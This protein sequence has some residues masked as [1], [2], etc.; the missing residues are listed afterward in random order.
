MKI[1]GSSVVAL[2]ALVLIACG[3]GGTAADAGSGPDASGLDTG[4]TG[5]D[6]GSGDTGAA[7][8]SGSAAGDSGAGTGD[9]S[10]SDA[11]WPG[12]GSAPTAV[13]EAVRQSVASETALAE[14]YCSCPGFVSALADL[15]GAPLDA[16][17]CRRKLVEPAAMWDCL[18]S[19]FSSAPVN[20]VPGLV[21]QLAG[22]LRAQACVSPL[23]CTASNTSA[24]TDCLLAYDTAISDCNL[25]GENPST[26]PDLIACID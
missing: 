15:V 21:C 17:G 5:P 7:G 8:D 11:G 14:A 25:R 24:A 12:D 6:A 20:K 1:S 9:A 4:S 3:G 10:I 16:A 19:T 13:D 2:L 18:S 22:S 26:P 23:E